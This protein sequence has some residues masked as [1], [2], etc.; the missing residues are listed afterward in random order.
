MAEIAEIFPFLSAIISRFADLIQ[1][2]LTDQKMLWTAVPLVIATLFITLY[3]GKYRQED[4]GWN[5]A[6]ENTMVFL[7][8]SLN[9]IQYMYYSTGTGSWDS[10]LSNSVY[11][12]STVGLAA[13]ALFLMIVT[14]YHL[15]PKKLAFFLFSAPP[16][17][18]TT[19]VIMTIVYTGVP[20]DIFTLAA[21]IM[22][23]LL[24]YGILRLLQRLER[25]AGKEEGITLLAEK[26]ESERLLDKM[27]EKN[28][29]IIDKKKAEAKTASAPSSPP[30]KPKTGW[31]G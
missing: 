25:M 31:T 18:V 6:F 15:L 10:V 2:P 30:S 1:A 7:F 11:L 12:S 14:Y 24:I 26:S 9:I 3:F 5:T 17:N 4:I 27:K 20:A 16:V 29:E 21:A 8:V 28:Q 23:F 19:Y 22:L 13:I